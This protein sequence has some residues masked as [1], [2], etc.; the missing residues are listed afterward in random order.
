MIQ[1][2]AE[3]QRIASALNDLSLR[4][5]NMRTGHFYDPACIPVPVF[6]GYPVGRCLLAQFLSRH[7][8]QRHN[9]SP[10]VA[11]GLK[12]EV[13]EVLPFARIIHCPQQGASA[14]SPVVYLYCILPVPVQT[15]L[16][17]RTVVKYPPA[18]GFH[19]VRQRIVMLSHQMVEHTV[20]HL[21]HIQHHLLYIRGRQHSKVK[22]IVPAVKPYPVC[23]ERQHLSAL[24][25]FVESYLG[26]FRKHI[27]PVQH[28][29]LP[30]RKV[31]IRVFIFQRLPVFVKLFPCFCLLLF[32]FRGDIFQTVDRR[33]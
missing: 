19:P 17:Q 9:H 27:H 21:F 3:R 24:Q 25:I 14:K 10:L 4:E 8:R 13:V 12:L 29:A 2:T 7:S 5:V 6:A 31:L 28:T 18:D 16:L 23:F 15:Q 30:V 1:R 33:S 32:I 26:C 22:P 11:G 20:R